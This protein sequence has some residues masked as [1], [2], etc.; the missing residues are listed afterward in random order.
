MKQEN[1]QRRF[2]LACVLLLGIALPT[3]A[4]EEVYSTSGKCG[5]AKWSAYFYCNRNGNSHNYSWWTGEK[6]P[7][8]ASTRLCHV[9]V[10]Q[11]A[12]CSTAYPGFDIKLGVSAQNWKDMEYQYTWSDIYLMKSDGSTNNMIKLGHTNTDNNYSPECYKLDCYNKA[13]GLISHPETWREGDKKQNFRHKMGMRVTLSRKAWDEDYTRLYIKGVSRYYKNPSVRSAVNMD[14]WFEYTIELKKPNFEA[15]PEPTYA[16]TSPTELSVTMNTKNLSPINSNQKLNDSESTRLGQ[17]HCGI[18]SSSVSTDYVIYIDTKTNGKWKNLSKQNFTISGYDTRVEK[19]KVPAGTPVRVRSESVTTSTLKVQTAYF[20][21]NNWYTDDATIKQVSDKASYSRELSAY[22]MTNLKSSFNQVSGKVSLLWDKIAKLP[23]SDKYHVYRTLL[24]DDGSFAGNREELGTTTKNSYEDTEDRGMAWGKKYRY[25]VCVIEDQWLKN[26]F[27]VATDPQQ[28]TG[29]SSSESKVSTKPNISLHLTQDMNETEKIKITWKFSNTPE[30]ENELNFRIHRI[31]SKGTVKTDYGSVS[32]HRKDGSATFS[33]DKPASN[34]DIYRYFVQLDMLDNSIH[35]VSDTLTAHITSSTAITDLDVSKGSLDEGVRVTWHAHQVGT[36]ATTYKVKRRFIGTTEWSVV[37]TTKGTD[38]EYTF[39]DNTTETGRYYE[40]LVEAY[41]ANCEDTNT[42]LLTS[43]RMTSGFGQATGTISGRV[44]FDTG[45]AVGNVKVNLMRSDDEKS[46]QNY[47][48]ARYVLESGKPLSWI[49]STDQLK[50]IM[51]AQKNWSVQMWVK[52]EDVNTTDRL[53]LFDVYRILTISLQKQS[54]DAANYRLRWTNCHLD[55]AS[56]NELVMCDSIPTNEYVHITVVHKTDTLLAYINGELKG[57]IYNKKFDYDQRL[58][59]YTGNHNVSFGGDKFTGY[60]DEVR[61]WNKA[62]SAE[63]VSTNYGRVLSG[64]EDGL[65]L[66]WPFDEGLDDYAFDVSRTN[67]VSND[68]HPD[69]GASK[70]TQV[71]PTSSQLGLYGMTNERGEYVIRGIPFTGSGTGYIVAPEYGVHE[72]SPNTRTGFVSPGSIALN[73]YDFSDIS[74]FKVS[75]KVYYAGTDVPVDSVQFQVDGQTCMADD[76]VVYTDANGEYTISV[77]IGFHHITA[78]RAGHTFEGDGRYPQEKGVNFEFRTDQT[79]NFT[80]NTLVHFAGRL[81]G[82][83]KEGLEP[84]GYG[85]SQNTI[86]QAT[87]QLESLDYPQCR[88]NVL[89]QNNGLETQIVNNKEN[90]SVASASDK[91]N[92]ESWRAG[93]DDNAMK[94]IYIKT[95]PKTGEFS[96]L[97]PPLRYRITNVKFEHNPDLE[98]APVFRNLNAVDL[99]NVQQEEVPDTC[100]DDDNHIGYEPLFKCV[101]SLRLTYRSPAKLDVTQIG[102]PAGF[103]GEDSVTV[104]VM[105]E[106]DVTL[107]VATVDDKG[108]VNYLYGY[109]IFDQDENYEF[110]IRAYEQYINYDADKEGHRYE[111]MLTDSIISVD[112]E[113][114]ELVLVAKEDTSNDSVSVK[115]GDIVHL[116]PGQLQLDS[117]GTA[118]YKWHASFPNLQK[119]FTRTMNIFTKVGNNYYSWKDNGFEGIVFGCIP[120]GNNFVTVGPDNVIMVLRDPPGANSSTLWQNDTVIVKT[121]DTM[122]LNGGEEK[123]AINFGGGMKQSIFTGVGVMS[124][125]TE[126]VASYAVTIGQEATIQAIWG[127]GKSTTL[128]R[129]DKITTNA[130]SDYV[131]SPGD[132]FIGFSKNYIFGEAMIVGL[133][134]QSDGSYALDMQKGTNIGDNFNTAFN[135]SQYYIENT[136]IPNLKLLRNQLLTHVNSRAEIPEKVTGT[137]PFFYTTLKPDDPRYG[138]SNCD[139]AVWGNTASAIVTPDDGPSYT[140]RVPENWIGVD[141][142]AFY[143]QAINNWINCLAENEKDK[144]EAINTNTLDRNVSWDRGSSRSH[145]SSSTYKDWDYGGMDI[146][147]K[148]YTNWKAG[149]SALVGGAKTFTWSKNEVGIVGHTTHKTTD[150]TDNVATFAYTLNDESRSAALSVDVFKSPKG[151]GPSFRTRGGQTRC[152]YEDEEKT[153]Y[154]NPG[155]VLNYATMKID[156]PKISIPDNMILDVPSGR[157]ATFEV[158]FTNESETSEELLVPELM[159][160]DNPNGLQLYIDGVPITGGMEIPLVFGAPTKKTVT[161]RQSDTS[162]LDYEN[163]E[164]ALISTCQFNKVYDSAKFSIHFTPSAP[165]ATLE[166][167]KSVVNSADVEGAPDKY[168]TVTAKDID[169]SFKG[170]KSVRVKYRFIGDNSWITAHEFFNSMDVVPDGKLQSGQSLLPENKSSVSHSFALPTIDGHYMVCVETTCLYG[171]GEVTWQSE[172]KEVVKD[173]HGPMLLGQAYPNTGILTPNEDIRVKF[174]EPIRANYLT[175]A[176]NFNIVGELNESPIDHYVSLQLNGSPV[177]Y[178]GQVPVTNADFAASMWLYRESSGTILSHGSA[179]N[180]LALSVD[181]NGIANLTV[182]GKQFAGKNVVIPANEWVFI[183]ASYVKN[184]TEYYYDAQ[185]S[186]YD[187][188]LTLFDHQVVPEYNNIGPLTIGDG[189]KGA[190]HELSVWNVERTPEQLREY[191]HKSIPVYKDGLLGY[192]RMNEG[193]GTEVVDC[194]RGR[195]MYLESE[196]WNLNNENMAAQLDGKSYI[197]AD[198]STE[199][200]SD[201]DN[202]MLSFWFKGDSG[203]NAG[204]SLF[205]LTDRMSLDFGTNNDLLLRTYRGVS[206]LTGDGQSILLTDVNYSDNEWHHFALNVRRGISA[207]VY[208]DGQ[209]VKTFSETEVPAFAGNYVFLGA[210]ERSVNNEVKA[211]ML[212][213]GAIDEFAVWEAT[214]DGTSLMESRYFQNDSTSSSLLVYYPM[215]HKYKDGNGVTQTEFSLQSG[216]KS[217]NGELRTAEGKGVVQALNAPPLKTMATRQNLDFDFTASDDEIYVTLKTPPSRMHGNLMSFT[218]QGVSDVYGNLSSPVT[219]TVRAN[220]STL[221][222]EI[223]IDEYA[224][225]SKDFSEEATIEVPLVNTG[226]QSCNFKLSSLPPYIKAD[227]TS[228]TIGVGQRETITFTVTASTPPGT[229]HPV[230]Y[231]S[232]NDGILEPLPFRIHVY[233]NVPEWNVDPTLYENSMHLIGQLYVKDRIDTQEMTRIYAFVGDE[234]RGIAYPQYI[235]SRDA[236]FTNLVVYGNDDDVNK[237]VTFRIYDGERGLVYSNVVTFV[238]DK[239]TAVKFISNLLTGNYDKPV[240]WNASEQIEQIASLNDNWNWV[241]LYVQPV[242][243]KASPSDVLGTNQAF[244]S[245]KDKPGNIS[246]L[247]SGG[248]EGSLATMAP[249]NMYK[250]HMNSSYTKPISGNYID[251]KTTKLTIHKDYNWIGSLSCF[252][253]TLN[254]AFADL[255]PEMGDYVIAKNGVAFYNGYEWDGTLQSIL[256]G[257]GYIYY[258]VSD[259]TKT[260]RFPDVENETAAKAPSR[261]AAADA[262]YPFTPVDHY[263]FPDN[264]NVIATL[265]DGNNMPVDTACV[266]AFID[267]ECRGVTRS[268]N[269]IY[270][271]PVPGR[272]EETGK[273]VQF[274]TFYDGELRNIAETS[275]FVS[276]NIEGNPEKPKQLTIENTVGITETLYAGINIWPAIT[277]RMVHVQSQKPLSSVMVYSTVGALLQV[278]KADGNDADID[279]MALPNGLYIVKATDKNG[280]VSV[281][282]IVKTGQP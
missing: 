126:A 176:K 208:I 152:P 256:P 22:A 54:A 217:T 31:D 241:S 261:S 80:D 16:F 169:R 264:M 181:N 24:N 213:K 13:Y 275:S 18:S 243:G 262:W 38:Q 39:L 267:G 225:V 274:R 67:G 94:N 37:H 254:D 165:Q 199:S 107:P 251:P 121:S 144:V 138:S 58:N 47:S 76:K 117:L 258:S 25:E 192:W 100:W 247:R 129:S 196:S 201:D 190:M 163:I 178:D 92:S 63:E 49:T 84:L 33:D 136:Q 234:C 223:Q 230:I 239:E 28:S 35:V 266:A 154:Y 211:D 87:L 72:F 167:D 17:R 276:D 60:L 56:Y 88:L 133:Y 74:S 212:F 119:P 104:T 127:G 238:D 240:K 118:V 10:N 83:E 46:G 2:W 253:L 177:Q 202:Y 97:L 143:N 120:T 229:L 235:D 245:I 161:V 170:F 75:G 32:A 197:K 14:N 19:L 269:G 45:T 244:S 204:A 205:S 171:T 206:S 185:M 20:L 30:K 207:N 168:L 23:S 64:R 147:A 7:V 242:D 81:T 226:S 164:L 42:P 110:K 86:G 173:T 180:Q 224:V 172:E 215:E 62:L 6:F 175:A 134:K 53:F 55:E 93:G 3:L 65:K 263:Q 209:P 145:T 257:V 260:F 79:I 8:M 15:G 71:T 70:C 218:V 113:M 59:T 220:Y 216:K 73:N 155:T 272:P 265:T 148:F 179:G 222:W 101:K 85:V 195:N 252:S 41:G 227:K 194:A 198:V 210:R 166:V 130:S 237:P 128:S 221:K 5:N 189:L 278:L 132:V 280:N 135:Y 116:E 90:L 268:I 158:V 139:K 27:S 162:I 78:Q 232:N 248:W 151:W 111:A 131:G 122:K 114:G 99:T 282:R 69:I 109:P 246:F 186:T 219:W 153:K 137:R 273:T 124:K 91:V 228:G 43:S 103:F 174:N 36:N 200:L 184:A 146:N 102:S 270:Y 279:L 157:D 182:G 193:H 141:S 277:S 281:K 236:Y 108:T 1:L 188:T 51:G 160:F 125:T 249:G 40:Y 52:P 89:T 255:R 140:M 66:Y 95:D 159:C 9:E 259:E 142:V 115:M 21:R 44:T 26:G 156:N 203:A 12:Q 61:L 82:G 96:A 123:V 271:I 231:A 98:N 250:V 233:G 191:M 4:D 149:A 183:T 68:N 150:E 105:G 48:F 11:D 214:I 34:C 29:C 106:D 57:T 50:T 112:N 77:P 187:E